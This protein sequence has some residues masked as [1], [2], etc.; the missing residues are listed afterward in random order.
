MSAPSLN[1]LNTAYGS[2][3]GSDA[4]SIL[5]YQTFRSVRSGSVRSGSTNF[6]SDESDTDTL[7]SSLKMNR[8]FCL[9]HVRYSVSRVNLVSSAENIETAF[10]SIL[11]VVIELLM[12]HINWD[13]EFVS[14]GK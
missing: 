13:N 3:I 9:K 12:S 2:C 10:S 14:A 5:S 4:D 1:S 6:Y 7:V 8:L 11:I